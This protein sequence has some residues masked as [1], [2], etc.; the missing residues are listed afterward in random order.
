MKRRLLEDITVLDLTWVM[1]GPGATKLFCDLGARVIK[2][3]SNKTLD[4]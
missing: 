3:E 4:V 1:A 2:V